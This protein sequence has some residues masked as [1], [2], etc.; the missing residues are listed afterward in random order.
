M[1]FCI[2]QAQKKTCVEVVSERS[3][4]DNAGPESTINFGHWLPN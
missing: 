2:K 1:M 4:Q 3:P